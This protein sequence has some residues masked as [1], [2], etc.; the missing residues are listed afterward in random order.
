MWLQKLPAYVQSG[1]VLHRVRAM[2][3]GAAHLPAKPREKHSFC[4]GNP[5]AIACRSRSEVLQNWMESG[6]GTL[7]FIKQA[8][9]LDTLARDS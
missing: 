9:V 7:C 2:P 4:A 5:P 3:Y 6:K 1:Q 8:C